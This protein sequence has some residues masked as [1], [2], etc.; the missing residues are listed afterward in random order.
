MRGHV[1]AESLALCAEGLLSTRRSARIRSHVAGCPECAATQARLAEVPALLAQVPP[2]ADAAGDRGPA[3]RRAER[4]G[5]PPRRARARSRRRRA[6]A[7]HP[8]P[9]R[10]R[11]RPGRPAARPVA[12]PAG[13][14]PGP[15]R[16]GRRWSSRAGWATRWLISSSPRPSG[17]Q[18]R[19]RPALRPGRIVTPRRTPVAPRGGPG[20]AAALS[21]PCATAGPGTAG[22]VRRPGRRAAEHALHGPD[23]PREGQRRPARPRATS[24]ALIGCV[25]KVAGPVA[26]RAGAVRLVDQ[27]RYQDRPATVIVVQATGRPA[28]DGLRG[29]DPLLRL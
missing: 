23:P 8:G 3:G 4:R 25:D 20:G 10:S 2:P 22:H 29:R 18:R 17:I 16:G 9:A 7:R 12:A 27:A 5:R 28:R 11:L 15:G 21:S 19:A 24:S 14:G 6:P 1:D 26:V 13:R